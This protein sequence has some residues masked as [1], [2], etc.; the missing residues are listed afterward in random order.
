MSIE[1]PHSCGACGYDGGIKEQQILG[2]IRTEHAKEIGELN[3][4]IARLREGERASGDTKLL[5]ATAMVFL[6]CIFGWLSWD[7][8]ISPPDNVVN[9]HYTQSPYEELTNSNE[10]VYKICLAK[11]TGES[12]RSSCKDTYVSLTEKLLKLIENGNL[13]DHDMESNKQD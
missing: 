5:F 11:S 6:A 13:K 7:S 12:E 1:D 3:V 2:Q 4:I 10:D 8:Y 9:K